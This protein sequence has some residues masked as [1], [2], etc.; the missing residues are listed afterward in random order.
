MS[1]KAKDKDIPNYKTLLVGAKDKNIT[2]GDAIS[3]DQ[4]RYNLL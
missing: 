1:K 4:S 2:L 3:T